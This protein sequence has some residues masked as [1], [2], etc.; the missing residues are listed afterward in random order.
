MKSAIE[1]QNEF[2]LLCKAM[3][4]LKDEKEFQQFLLDIMTPQEI[5]AISARLEVA[6]RLYTTDQPYRQIAKET[7]VSTTTVTR[8]NDWLTR[9]KG[10]YKKAL[11]R[12]FGENHSHHN[13]GKSA[14]L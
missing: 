1:N 3:A 6:K 4:T 5:E 12:L 8:V 2:K 14:A 7:S 11:A 10:G 13:A 9:G